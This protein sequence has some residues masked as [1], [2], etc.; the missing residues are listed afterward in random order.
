MRVLHE[1]ERSEREEE[2]LLSD[3]TQREL[4]VL[5][6]IVKG[7]DNKSIGRTLDIG[8][9]TVRAHVQHLL[10]KL[11]AHSKLEVAAWAVQRGLATA[12]TDGNHTTRLRR[13]TPPEHT[14]R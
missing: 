6:L 1:K 12:P 5:Q 3:L 11:G 14:A 9:G 10:H 7:L 13:G 8:T 4:E 2:R